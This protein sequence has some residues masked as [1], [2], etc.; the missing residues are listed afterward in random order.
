[1]QEGGYIV[2]DHETEQI[3]AVAGYSVRTKQGGVNRIRMRVDP[4]CPEI[5]P[6][7]LHHLVRTCQRLGAGQR[8]MLTIPNW[9]AAVIEAANAA[10]C[11]QRLKYHR[12][13]MLL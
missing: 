9:Q 1:M 8:I 7:L 6:H 11:V 13:G 3:I 2:H 12:M 10:G 5:A 4:A